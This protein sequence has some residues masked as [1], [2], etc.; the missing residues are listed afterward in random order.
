MIYRW[1]LAHDQA[2]AVSSFRHGTTNTWLLSWF[3]KDTSSSS[4]SLFIFQFHLTVTWSFIKPRWPPLPTTLTHTTPVSLQ[5]RSHPPLQSYFSFLYPK[6][7]FDFVK[8]NLLQTPLPGGKVK[9]HPNLFLPRMRMRDSTWVASSLAPEHEQVR[10][11][12]VTCQVTQEQQ[13]NF[14]PCYNEVLSSL[15]S[16]YIFT[17]N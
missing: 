14:I 8:I 16:A 9:R 17:D 10:V 11:T 13:W 2:C 5:P 1:A 6:R 15:S 7:S 3:Y 4:S 12:P